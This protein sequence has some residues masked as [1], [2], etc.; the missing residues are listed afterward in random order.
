MANTIETT[1][2]SLKHIETTYRFQ[3]CSFG[4]FALTIYDD[5]GGYE[6]V[7]SERRIR[8]YSVERFSAMRKWMD[9]CIAGAI[10]D[11]EK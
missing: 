7:F 4:N 2:E 5:G 8:G 9:A 6:V 10:K 11:Y 1:V 3:N